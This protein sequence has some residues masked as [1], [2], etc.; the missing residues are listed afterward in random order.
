MTYWLIDSRVLNQNTNKVQINLPDVSDLIFIIFL[1]KWTL[2]LTFKFWILQFQLSTKCFLEV[3]PAWKKRSNIFIIFSLFSA[4]LSLLL[5]VLKKDGQVVSFIINSLWLIRESSVPCYLTNLAERDGFMPFPNVLSTKWTQTA[6][7]E[8]WT[9][10][11]NFLCKCSTFSTFTLLK[12]IHWNLNCLLTVYL[13]NFR[14]SLPANNNKPKGQRE[15]Y[16]DSN[17]NNNQNE[18]TSQSIS[19][20]KNRSTPQKFRQKIMI[21]K[22]EENKSVTRNFS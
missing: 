22:N 10:F 16:W 12:Q 2:I 11:T 20:Y 14:W 1:G 21:I 3:L 8:S 15:K 7:V 19:V 6:R 17:N 9:F 13:K 4:V 18:D 5:N